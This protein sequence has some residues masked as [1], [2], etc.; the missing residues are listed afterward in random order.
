MENLRIEEWPIEHLSDDTRQLKNWDAALPKM[1]EALTVWAWR[2]GMSSVLTDYGCLTD[3]DAVH[4]LVHETCY[5]F[6]SDCPKSGQNLGIWRVGMDSGSTRTAETVVSRTEEVYSFVRRH[7]AGKVFACNGAN[8]E[9]HTPV[10]TTSIDRMPISRVRIPGGLWLY[11]LDTHYFIS[12]IFA[13]LEAD[14]RQPITL[15]RKTDESFAAQITAVAQPTI[16]PLRAAQPDGARGTDGLLPDRALPARTVLTR[17][18]PERPIANRP[19][20]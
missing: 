1:L 5:N 17:S 6:E 10:R 18:L 12:L 8:S 2:P 3:W 9:T 11:I 13:R 16:R 19:G 20:F 4:A 15:H 7:G 14:A